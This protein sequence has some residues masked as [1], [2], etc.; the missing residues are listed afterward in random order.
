V[1]TRAVLLV[2]GEVLELGHQHLALL[3]RVHGDE[4]TGGPSAA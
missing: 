4:V 1:L 2:G 3:A